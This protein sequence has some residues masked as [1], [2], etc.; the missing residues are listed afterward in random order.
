MAE[1]PFP[2]PLTDGNG[3]GFLSL[4]LENWC[5]GNNNLQTKLQVSPLVYISAPTRQTP[6]EKRFWSSPRH[7]HAGALLRPIFCL[8]YPH[9]SSHSFMASSY[10]SNSPGQCIFVGQFIPANSHPLHV[11]SYPSERMCGN[12]ENKHQRRNCDKATYKEKW[13]LSSLFLPKSELLSMV[14]EDISV[15]NGICWNVL[16][17]L[18]VLLF[19]WI[20]HLPCNITILLKSAVIADNASLDEPRMF[21]GCEYANP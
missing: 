17:S 15:Q 10:A 20:S 8:L 16:T 11:N 4:F 19:P 13:L 5:N 1:Q 7:P 14:A 6:P 3:I 18:C 9:W 21:V 2:L 12:L